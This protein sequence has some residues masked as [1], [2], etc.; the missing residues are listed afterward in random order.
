[1]TGP[2]GRHKG[3]FENIEYGTGGIMPMQPRSE[4]SV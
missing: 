1:M 2:F 4:Y 3:G